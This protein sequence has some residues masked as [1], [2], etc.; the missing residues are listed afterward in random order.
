MRGTLLARGAA[1]GGQQR[2]RDALAAGPLGDVHRVDVPAGRLDRSRIEHP[3]WPLLVLGQED[4]P[5]RRCCGASPANRAPRCRAR[6]RAAPAPPRRTPAR[7]PWRA[8]SSFSV[9]A[10]MFTASGRRSAGSARRGSGRVRG[11]GRARAH[12]NGRRDR[13]PCAARGHRRARRAAAR[14]AGARNHSAVQ[15]PS[16]RTAI[17]RA[18]TSSSESAGERRRGRARRG[19]GRSRTRPSAARSRARRAPARSPPRPAPGSGTRRSRPAAT[20]EPL[21]Q[22]VA[23]RDGR[24]QRDLLR[25]DRR[26]E[27]LERVG[28]ERRAEAGEPRDDLGEH[29]VARGPGKERVELELEPEQLLDDRARLVVE[30]LDRRRPRARRR[31]APRARRR[32]GAVRRPRSG[33]RDRAR[34]R[35]S[36]RS[37]GRSRT[38]RGSAAASC[39][40]SP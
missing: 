17:R 37:R 8:A 27:R 23:D 33:S 21:D 35:G 36:A 20:A 22:A 6:T 40:K 19:R 18:R 28:H 30:R 4:R 2:L 14:G 13:P 7:A 38:A 29:R 11:G 32:P 25:G 34:R 31:S 1:A 24:A 10:R 3:E 9:A 12:R 5:G 26:H 39:V 16:P 15:G